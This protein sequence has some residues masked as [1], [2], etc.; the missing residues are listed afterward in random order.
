MKLFKIFNNE[1]SRNSDS[2]NAVKKSL[3]KLDK[4]QLEKMI[5]GTS[6]TKS[7][8]TPYKDCEANEM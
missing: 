6:T 7:T 8:A 5:G 2:K 3:T 4:T 1:F